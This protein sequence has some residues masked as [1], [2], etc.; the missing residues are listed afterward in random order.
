[1]KL[2]DKIAFNRLIIT[3]TSF[4][5]ALARILVPK[6]SDDTETPKPNKRKKVLPWRN[7]K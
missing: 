4:I 3:L 1:M 2:L 7:K 5:L 6:V